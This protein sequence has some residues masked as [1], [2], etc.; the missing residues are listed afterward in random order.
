MIAAMTEP[1]PWNALVS[2]GQEN[3]FGEDGSGHCFHEHSL[4]FGPVSEGERGLR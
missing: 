3:T 4:G 1:E 2:A